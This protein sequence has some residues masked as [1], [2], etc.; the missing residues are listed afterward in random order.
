MR[1]KHDVDIKS[2]IRT[3][4]DFPKPGVLFRDITTL[5]KR[6]DGLR[7]VVER[8]S[9]A[10]QGR[11]ID[12]IAAIESRGF[13]VGAALAYKLGVGLVPI[14]KRGKLPAENFGH[15]YQLEY[16]ADRLEMHTDA[17]EPGEQ[18]LLVDDL[19]ATGGTAQAALK[20]IEIGGGSVVGCAFVIE[21]PELGGRERIEKLGY[22]VLALCE[23]SGH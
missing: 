11:R 10:Y 18:V 17:M 5:L 1:V 8:L 22:P 6:A 12:K 21:L 7:A 15:D 3:V 2:L 16:G 23:F 19:I 20:L 13:I 14:R 9:K 4:P